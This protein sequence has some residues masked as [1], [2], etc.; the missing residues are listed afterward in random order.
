MAKGF[1]ARLSP[2][3]VICF[4]NILLWLLLRKEFD[5]GDERG[6]VYEYFVMYVFYFTLFV[7]FFCV[8]ASLARP[9]LR[10]GATCRAA[11][12]ALSIPPAAFS[13]VVGLLSLSVAFNG[14]FLAI[15]PA[16]LYFIALI[17]IAREILKKTFQ[18][19]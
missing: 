16:A 15:F 5:S 18:I 14:A 3:V 11:Y 9:G 1:L 10:G 4:A 12:F 13:L 8:A 17:L 6:Q 2:L 7:A 19:W